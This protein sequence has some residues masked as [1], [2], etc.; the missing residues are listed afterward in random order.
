VEENTTSVLN[1]GCMAKMISEL[2]VFFPAYNEEGNIK[3]T[4]VKAKKVLEEIADKWEILIIN[5]GSTDKTGEI[6]KKLS[7]EDGRIRVKSHKKNRGYGAGLKT[8][9]YNCRY[10]WI[11]YT[12][13]DGQFDFSE[14]TNFIETQKKTRADLVIGYYLDRKVPLYRKF[15]TLLWKL[16]VFLTFELSVRD[17][18]TGFKLI[19]KK[20]IDKID[21]LESERGAFIESEMLIKAK[22]AG[23]KIVEIGVHHYPRTAGQGTGAD[24]NVVVKSFVDLFGLWKKL[25]KS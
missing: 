1:F 12:D 25:R 5:D 3:D 7:G 9:L 18:D 16:V 2:S 14:I 19:S 6:A 21:R 20:V 4:V 10:A 8:G 22:K 23:F 11:A 24:F 15:N 13:S 17:V